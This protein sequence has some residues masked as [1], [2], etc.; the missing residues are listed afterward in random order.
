MPTYRYIKQTR[1]LKLLAFPP[2]FR[3]WL[4]ISN[5]PDNTTIENWRELHAIIWEDLQ[6]PFAD[7]FILTNFNE[8]LPH[9]VTIE[10][11]PEILTAHPHDTIHSWGDYTFS[12]SKRFS[13]NDAERSLELLDKIG[14]RPRIWS[15]HSH[16]SG[17]MLHHSRLGAVPR[18]IDA[19]GNMYENYEY[20][21]DLVK[22]LGVRYLWDGRMKDLIVGQDRP[23][24]RWEWYTHLTK[25]DIRGGILAISDVLGKHLWQ[26]M[27]AATF[28]YR[29]DLNRAYFPHVFPDEQTF[30]CFQRYGNPRLADIDGLAEVI[31][32]KNIDRLIEVGGTMIVYTHLG[33]RPVHRQHDSRHI[34]DQTYQALKNVTHQY[35]DQ[36]V[37]VSSTSKLLDYL[38]L[39][40]HLMLNETTVDFRADGIRF[41]QLSP[42]DLAGFQFGFSI[43][44][45][46]QDITITCEGKQ[47]EFDMKIIDQGVV[48]ISFPE[49]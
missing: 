42:S 1:S 29:S 35:R 45:S 36:N 3:A 15:D 32:P 8:N 41:L 4:T 47:I 31:S 43:K 25:S 48:L 7:T 9:Q 33:K 21:L 27:N 49:K 23:L 2:P 13:R 40:D 5:D 34:P 38:V 18:V 12:S 39:R 6:L 30:Y 19:S 17:N 28:S 37:M 14:I 26:R 24:N 16:F 20:T 44:C 22:R 11:H 46:P 10:S